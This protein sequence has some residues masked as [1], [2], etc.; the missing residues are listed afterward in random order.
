MRLFHVLAAGLLCALLIVPSLAF[1][2]AP[3]N[4]VR[5]QMVTTK[6]SFILELYPD[7]APA[8][9]ANFLEYV[10]SGFYD[11]TIFHR[12]EGAF[13]IQGGGYDENL[14]AKQTRAPIQN[15]ADNGL[16][17]EAYTI[18][19]ARTSDPHSATSQFYINT[20]WN[21]S[22]DF[23]AKTMQGWG[24]CVFGKVFTGKQT[25][26]AIASVKTHKVNQYMTTVPVDPV[27]I[28]RATILP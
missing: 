24:Y 4:T 16:S 7:K 28:Q 2:Q 5:V 23:T 12:I 19:M 3:E 22:L 18:A 8:T 20:G 17:N 10:R 13:V 11:G 27:I 1:A 14:N 6:G 25:I 26:D 21:R 9:V 15:E